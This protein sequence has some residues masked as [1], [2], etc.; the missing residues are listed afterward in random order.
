MEVGAWKVFVW[1]ELRVTWGN[2][3]WFAKEAE[4]AKK[5]GRPESAM[6]R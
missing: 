5:E 4:E 2:D 1:R 6:K 3:V